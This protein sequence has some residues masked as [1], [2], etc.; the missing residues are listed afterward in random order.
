M[1]ILDINWMDDEQK[2]GI[3]TL[4]TGTQEFQV[5]CY[6]CKFTKGDVITL[7]LQSLDDQNLVRVNEHQYSIEPIGNTFENQIIARVEDSK[8]GIVSVGQIKIELGVNLP[9]DISEGETVLF[10]SMRLQ[11]R[12]F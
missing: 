9:G 10:T 3:L 7:P 11:A 4:S 1:K 8:K 6:P 5:Y 12:K 2:E